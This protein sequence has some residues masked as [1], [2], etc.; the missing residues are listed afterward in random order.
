MKAASILTVILL[1]VCINPGISGTNYYVN[2]LHGNNQWD[3]LA[4]FHTSGNHGPKATMQS[5]VNAA[6]SLDTVNMADQ[7]Y[8][9][10]L[11]INKSLTISCSGTPSLR[12]LTIRD[13]SQVSIHGTLEITAALTITA[14]VISV[15]ENQSIIITNGSS[16]AVHMTSGS[17]KGARWP[18]ANDLGCGFHWP[19]ASGTRSRSRRVEAISCSNS[20]NSVAAML[21]RGT[22]VVG[23][24]MW[25]RDGQ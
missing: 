11:V 5:A 3:G 1:V 18:R 24:A 7:W 4:P 6:M 16:S 20:G 19:F 9:E 10:S 21:M 23:S 12:S 25:A 8:N 17:I 22:L 2:P 13:N 14:G 15:D